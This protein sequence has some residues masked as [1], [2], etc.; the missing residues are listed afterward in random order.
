MPNNANENYS[1]CEKGII[2]QHAMERLADPSYLPSHT[3]VE[4]AFSTGKDYWERS[5][6][7]HAFCNDPEHTIYEFVNAEF[8]QAFGTYLASRAEDMGATEERPVRILE[9]GAGDGKLTHFLQ[10]Q[11][12]Q[13]SPGLVQVVATDSGEWDLPTAYP[14]EK[15]DHK[16]ALQKFQPDI[17]FIS[18]MPVDVD[19]TDDIRE[20][21]S[22]AEYLL[23]G[24]AEGGC[25]GDRWLTW[26]VGW[27]LRPGEWDFQDDEG[28]QDTEA[29]NEAME[30]WEEEYGT[31][32]FEKDGFI[33]GD[34]AEISETQICRS[35][36]PGS[37]SH[38]ST[39]SFRK[40]VN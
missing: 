17:V 30:K 13:A 29:Y 28:R 25:C 20:C 32:P 4:E 26:G 14:V 12:D 6:N 8:V 7:F 24:E 40:L 2:A 15:M 10:Q 9:I 21:P 18:W 16:T 39:V 11:L 23:I 37:Y 1:E 27:D 19:L 3:D 5:Y 33:R 22:V 38:S 34:L 36:S 31:T 35:D